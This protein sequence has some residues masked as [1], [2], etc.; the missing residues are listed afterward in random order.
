VV[1]TEAEATSTLDAP[2]APSVDEAEKA[3]NET[4]AAE[5]N[6]SQ[7]PTEIETVTISEV[8]VVPVPQENAIITDTPIVHNEPTT[9]ATTTTLTEEANLPNGD[10]IITVEEQTITAIEV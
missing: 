4:P 5:G 1:E 7:S 8:Q 3:I 10:Q 2:E 9:I 6:V